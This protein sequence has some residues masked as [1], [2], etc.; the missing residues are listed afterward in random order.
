VD[1][2]NSLENLTSSLRSY[3]SYRLVRESIRQNS[4]G[5]E[6]AEGTFVEQQPP[7]PI[8]TPATSSLL[9][10]LGVPV[11]Y[12]D[13][14]QGIEGRLRAKAEKSRQLIVQLNDSNGQIMKAAVTAR[15]A[16]LEPLNASMDSMVETETLIGL[17][18]LD[19]RLS[20]LK[21]QIELLHLEEPSREAASREK[22]L[23]VWK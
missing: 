8:P 22:F 2:T 11:N 17:Q 5:L 7:T 9:L 14:D 23:R 16:A 13:N 10:H 20:K 1:L 4:L 15:R 12:R 3:Q 21:S 6:I 19:G 18:D